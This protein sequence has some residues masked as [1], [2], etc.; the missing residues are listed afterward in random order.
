MKFLSDVLSELQETTE[1]LFAVPNCDT[2][3][4]PANVLQARLLC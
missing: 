1:Y 3:P 2:M 4:R